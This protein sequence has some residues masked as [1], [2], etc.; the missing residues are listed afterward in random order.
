MNKEYIEREALIKQFDGGDEMKSISESIH[1][2]L[3]VEALKKAPTADVAPVVHGEWIKIDYTT[4]YKC[5]VCT[6]MTDMPYQKKLFNH[7]PNCGAYMDG[8]NLN[9]QG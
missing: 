2:S 6:N 7:C 3:F 8:G 5:S 1:D 4:L 9:V